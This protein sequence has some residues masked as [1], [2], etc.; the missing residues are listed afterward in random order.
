MNLPRLPLLFACLL[1]A[2]PAAAVTVTLN[3]GSNTTSLLSQ[4]YADGGI[5]QQKFS[6][7][8]T[9]PV[10]TSDTATA[11]GSSVTT[12]YGLSNAAL[13]ITFSHAR[14]G[15]VSGS[16][17]SAFSD[18]SIYFSVDA[19]VDYE[20]AGSY[21]AVDPLGR[22]VFLEV[23]LRDVTNATNLFYNKQESYSTVDESFTL[24]GAGGDLDNQSTGSLT[25]TLLPGNEYLFDYSVLIQAYPQPA[26]DAAT[27]TGNVTLTL[28]PEPSTALLFSG[29][30]LLLGTC[31]RGG[32]ARGRAG[33]AAT[34][35]PR[36]A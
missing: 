10:S 29:G 14:E 32:S 34:A 2:S 9:L 21:T 12:T 35:A 23:T 27:A 20:L 7:P 22:R 26:G 8:T 25:G 17:A 31:R 18:G 1:W 13:D 33:S 3:P 36:R 24:G 6:N 15:V 28:V 19:A 11:G 4:A 5:I 30:L 16:Q